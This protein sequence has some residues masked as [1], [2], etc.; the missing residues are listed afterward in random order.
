MRKRG[1][2]KGFASLGK[3]GINRPIAA[4]PD[5]LLIHSSRCGMQAFPLHCTC[6]ATQFEPIK[7]GV[8]L[9]RFRLLGDVHGGSSVQSKRLCRACECLST[10]LSSGG[11]VLIF[12]PRRTS[13]PSWRL[14]AGCQNPTTSSEVL[15]FFFSTT[16][17]STLDA[18]RN[19][20]D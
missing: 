6:H 14:P 17:R 1:F 13:A 7:A 12:R 3:V 8:W 20:P 2:L 11:I 19:K 5:R 10:A 4:L 15:S 9:I 18:S 16:L